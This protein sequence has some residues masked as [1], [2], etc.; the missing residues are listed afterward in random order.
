MGIAIKLGQCAH[1]SHMDDV[2]FEKA[3]LHEVNV[4][5]ASASAWNVKSATNI[6]FL[7]YMNLFYIKVTSNHIP[8]FAI[9]LRNQALDILHIYCMYVT[10]YPRLWLEV[11]YTVVCEGVRY[12]VNDGYQRRERRK[13]I[14]VVVHYLALQYCIEFIELV[15][16]Q[17]FLLHKDDYKHNAKEGWFTVKATSESQYLL[18]WKAK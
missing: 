6:S 14:R 13:W 17:T 8:S 11:L 7:Y 2:A 3:C 15:L 1:I 18:K 10:A 12:A 16:V 9:G 5:S 4:F